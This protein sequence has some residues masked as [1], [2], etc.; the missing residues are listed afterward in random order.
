MAT[1]EA[2]AE[3]QEIKQASEEPMQE[4][5]RMGLSET[6]ITHPLRHF[7]SSGWE[8]KI[9]AAFSAAGRVVAGYGLYKGGRYV[10]EKVV[11]RF[12]G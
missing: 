11:A 8:N 4:T 1:K 3:K 5:P 2:T 9:E 7:L 10:V 12:G 6:L